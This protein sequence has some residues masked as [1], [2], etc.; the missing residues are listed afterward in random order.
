MS[1]KWKLFL[2]GAAFTFVSALC[3]I[4]W[5][6]LVDGQ[7]KTYDAT[8]DNL[9]EIQKNRVYISGLSSYV[10]DKLPEIP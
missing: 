7:Q 6:D 5:N 1:E 2:A 10:A 8:Q 3:A 9:R 4:I